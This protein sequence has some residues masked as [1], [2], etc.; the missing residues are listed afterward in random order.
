MELVQLGIQLLFA[1]YVM[2]YLK[3]YQ[4]YLIILERY[5][6]I[7]L[8]NIHT[9]TVP[10]SQ[11]TA[12]AKIVRSFTLCDGTQV[13]MACST[14]SMHSFKLTCFFF[15]YFLIIFYLLTFAMLL[16]YIGPTSRAC[17]TSWLPC[18]PFNNLPCAEG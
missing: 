12:C 8:Y 1:G 9:C 2:Q 6:D 16:A 11:K 5:F 3:S 14:V 13:Y 15:N 10:V 18:V 4:L 17:R 7:S